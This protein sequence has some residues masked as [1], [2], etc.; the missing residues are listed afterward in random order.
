MMRPSFDRIL[1]LAAAAFNLGTAAV[2]LFKPEIVL[3]RLGIADASARLLARSLVSSAATWGVGYALVAVNAKRF[4][5]FAWLGAISKTLF[6][7]IYAAAFFNGRVTATACVPAL[8][9]FIFAVL[10]VDFL[11]R[12]KTQKGR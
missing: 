8:I 12:T 9:D 4:R 5:D 2:L 11:R 6:A 3:A 10:F 7:L 1:F